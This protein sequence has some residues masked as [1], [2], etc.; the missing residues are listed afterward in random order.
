[1]NALIA[2]LAVILAAMVA[3]TVQ[4]GAGAVVLCVVVAAG[5][6]AAIARV[7]EH[8]TFLLQIFVGGL[9]VRMLIGTLIYGLGLQNFFGGDALT[10]DILGHSLTQSVR[11]NQAAMIYLKEWAAAGGG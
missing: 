6:G 2:A 7:R 9:L 1:M 10:Y 4:G 8:R 3:L 5:A 11:G